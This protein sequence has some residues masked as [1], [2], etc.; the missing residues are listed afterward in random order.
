MKLLNILLET[1]KEEYTLNLKEGL[2]KT[3]NKGKTINILKTKFPNLEIENGTNSFGIKYTLGKNEF[4]NIISYINN[5]GWFPSFLITPIYKGKYNEKNVDY[6]NSI[7]AF[8]AKY[9]IIVEKNPP[10]VYHISPLQNWEKIQKI[11]LVPKS[12][13]KSSYHP[14]RVYLAKT[15]KAAEDLGQS[16]YQRTGI[17]DWVILEIDTDMVPGGYLKLY[18]DPNYKHG[19]YTLNNI[20]PQAIEKIQDI[21]I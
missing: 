13:S 7:I 21:K 17:K 3:T 8:E 4:K 15:P 6:N 11:G 20:P 9:D 18:Y 10:F 2:I 12:R 1:Y 16:F 5:L 14:E 19:Y